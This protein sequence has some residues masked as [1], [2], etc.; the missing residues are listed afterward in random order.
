[1]HNTSNAQHVHTRACLFAR[2]KDPVGNSAEEA[3][4]VQADFLDAISNAL[5][6]TRLGCIVY[7]HF[8]RLRG[9]GGEHVHVRQHLRSRNSTVCTVLI[10]VTR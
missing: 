5:A 6:H 10:G 7:A 2:L 4:E 1:M 9:F 3:G 8:G